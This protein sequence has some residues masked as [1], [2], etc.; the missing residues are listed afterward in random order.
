LTDYFS[1]TGEMSQSKPGV[2]AEK[3]KGHTGREKTEEER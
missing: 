2:R 3:E 1:A